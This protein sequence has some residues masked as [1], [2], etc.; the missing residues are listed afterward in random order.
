MDPVPTLA[1][2]VSLVVELFLPGTIKRLILVGRLISV[3]G[4]MLAI[5]ALKELVRRGHSGFR[6]DLVGDGPMRTSL[7]RYAFDHGLGR[8][9][10]FRG[11]VAHE[12]SG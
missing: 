5:Q 3:K 9:V 1:L 4:A 7:Q 6:L 8:F 11:Q 12:D 2:S 10:S